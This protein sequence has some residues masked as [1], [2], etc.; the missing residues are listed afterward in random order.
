MTVIVDAD[1]FGDLSRRYRRELQVHCYRML[2]SADLAEEHVQE[3]FLRAWRGRDTFEER[4]SP[5]TWLYRIATNACLDTLRRPSPPLQPYPDQ[6]LDDEPGPESVAVSRETISLAFMV[7]IRLLPPRQR[8]VF[9][10][11]D[12]LAFPAADTAAL[13]GIGVTAANSALQRARAT[14]RSHWP[15]GRLAWRAEAGPQERELLRRYIE[16][17][18]NAD[19]DALVAVLGDDVRMTI[20]GLGTWN[21]REELAAA[22]RKDMNTPGRWRML[23]VAAN[24]QPA[25]AAYVCPPG[26]SRYEAFALI[27]LAA[28]DGRLAEIDVWHDPALFPAFGVPDALPL[29]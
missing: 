29:G 17:H 13:L 8:A 9:V 28:R 3:V 12:V 21:G 10:L 6:L 1:T 2:G 19:P 25:V 5:R 14:L 26:G 22:L 24:R 23:P 16:A 15:D 18:E 7:A 27:V 20:E 11:R 4:A